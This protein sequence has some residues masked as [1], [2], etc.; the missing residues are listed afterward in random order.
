MFAAFHALAVDDAGRRGGGAPGFL[1]A[2]D[3]ERMMGVR[4]RAIPGPQ[5]VVIM[6]GALG[7]R[8]LATERHRQNKLDGC[9]DVLAL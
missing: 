9:L 8:S 2:H 3:K 5:A 7:G 1:P 4:V 6:G